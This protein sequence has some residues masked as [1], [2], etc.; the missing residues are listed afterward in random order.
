M[1]LRVYQIGLGRFE[2]VKYVGS[3]QGKGHLSGR[4]SKVETVDATNARLSCFK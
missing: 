3:P 4:V 1:S 2:A